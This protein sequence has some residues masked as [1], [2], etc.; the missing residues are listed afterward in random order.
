MLE[1]VTGGSIT[2]TIPEAVDVYMDILGSRSLAK[3]HVPPAERE[4]HGQLEYKGLSLENPRGESV[5]LTDE[6]VIEVHRGLD[7]LFGAKHE[8]WPSPWVIS[9]GEVP[10]AGQFT[11]EGMTIRMR[12]Y[13]D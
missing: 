9:G 5:F 12:V 8:G 13:G 1:A 6:Q 10:G 11:Y 3:K 4:L 2:L 7:T